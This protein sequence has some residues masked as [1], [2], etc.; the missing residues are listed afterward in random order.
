MT[1]SSPET[2][3][4]AS[5][6]AILH[7]SSAHD[8]AVLALSLLQQRPHTDA[9]LELA[10]MALRGADIDELVTADAQMGGE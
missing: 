2:D 8:R 4:A 9:T 10:V 7:R 6:P 5:T 3:A 1:S